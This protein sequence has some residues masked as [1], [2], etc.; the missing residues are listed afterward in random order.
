[1]VFSLLKWFVVI[2]Y[3]K[4]SNLEHVDQ[5]RLELF[6]QTNRGMENLP[7]TRAALLQHSLISVYQASIWTTSELPQQ[8]RPSPASWGWNLDEAANTW[9]PLWTT[10]PV[11]SKACLELIKCSCKS[12]KG[13]GVRCGCKKANLNCT[14]VT[15]FLKNCF[16]MLFN[17]IFHK[18]FEFLIFAMY[19]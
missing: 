10:L 16:I 12:S 13:C 14:D 9:S 7:P 4:T 11:A 1:M 2:M 5:A 3:N 17:H 8:N 19:L 6:C 18:L 15:A